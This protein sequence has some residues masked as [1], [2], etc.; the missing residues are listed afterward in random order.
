MTMNNTAI[1]TNATINTINYTAPT[2][3]TSAI[4]VT[5]NMG[6]WG[7]LKNDKKSA[8]KIAAD[9]NADIKAVSTK[10]NL[11][12]DCDEL[13]AITSFIAETRRWFNSISFVWN[14]DGQR[15]MPMMVYT[16]FVAEITRSESEFWTLVDAL[17]AAYAQKQ[18]NAQI[19]L[20]GLHNPDDYP[21]TATVRNKFK[22]NVDYAPVPESGH[23]V[24]DLQGQARDELIEQFNARAQ[25]KWSRAFA[26]VCEEFR[27]CLGHLLSKLEDKDG[28]KQ[29]RLHSSLIPNIRKIVDKVRMA[30]ALENNA[31]VTAAVDGLERVLSGVSLDAL[32]HNEGARIQVR[33]GVN[34]LLSKFDF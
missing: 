18:Y 4:L 29:T 1:N 2:L 14:D 15:L 25:S 20:G 34:N 10:K 19:Q 7:T 6:S 17:I 28:D 8:E 3:S 9:N 32:K 13:K 33:E 22:F 27:K 24:V 31:D 16:D 12:P 5:L 26:E 11:L 21:D 23:F 30:N